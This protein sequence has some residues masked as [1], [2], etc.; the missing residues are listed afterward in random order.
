[1]GGPCRMSL[2]YLGC[3]TRVFGLHYARIWIALICHFELHWFIVERTS[4]D[5]LRS[6]DRILSVSDLGFASYS[7]R[8]F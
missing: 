1:M 4:P 7:R 8:A 6:A 5:S 2:S 3:T